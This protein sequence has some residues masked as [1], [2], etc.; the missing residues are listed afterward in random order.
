MTHFDLTVGLDDEDLML[1]A[2]AK[3]ILA[4][5]YQVRGASGWSGSYPSL[6]A[7][8]DGWSETLMT[9]CLNVPRFEGVVWSDL[10][11]RSRSTRWS[12]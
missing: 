10:E 4:F 1:I 9:G 7:T 12:G 2:E 8:T 3:D 5:V 11:G 6:T